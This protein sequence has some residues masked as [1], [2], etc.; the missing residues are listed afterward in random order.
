MK[1]YLILLLTLCLFMCGCEQQ[2]IISTELPPPNDI[3]TDRGQLCDLTQIPLYI[4]PATNV[5]GNIDFS[6]T[7][8]ITESTD[9]ES[10]NNT[11][12]SI[13]NISYNINGIP[14]TGSSFAQ[15][16][17]TNYDLKISVTYLNGVL[18]TTDEFSVKFKASYGQL[19]SVSKNSCLYDDDR[20]N[21][22][23][24]RTIQ[25]VILAD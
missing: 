21:E 8:P 7:F 25:S 22:I 19:T 17:N 6:T 11:N 4:L 15:Q 10:Y 13:Q 20:S 24:S 3:P 18:P 1:Q 2:D 5:Q 14:T 23:D 16:N 12:V 9:Y